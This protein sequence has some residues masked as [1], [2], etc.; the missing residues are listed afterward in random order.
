MLWRRRCTWRALASAEWRSTRPHPR[1]C[2]HWQGLL[3]PSPR[4]PAMTSDYQQALLDHH[5]AVGEWDPIKD[6]LRNRPIPPAPP[7]PAPPPRVSTEHIDR[8][9]AVVHHVSH[10]GPSSAESRAAAAPSLTAQFNNAL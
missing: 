3:L 8:L 9:A 1:P 10:H 4:D 7:P 2:R 5:R 6:G